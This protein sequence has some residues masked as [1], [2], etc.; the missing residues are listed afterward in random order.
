MPPNTASPAASAAAP[1]PAT[2]ATKR[3]LSAGAE[4]HTIPLITSSPPDR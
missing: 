1:A 4:R 2:A 3:S